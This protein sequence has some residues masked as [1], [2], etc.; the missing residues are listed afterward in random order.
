M[1]SLPSPFCS[2]K[3][4]TLSALRETFWKCFTA[5]TILIRTKSDSQNTSGRGGRR[6]K[7]RRDAPNPPNFSR[8]P[9]LS[10]P[11]L[12]NFAF[13]LGQSQHTQNKNNKK[14]KCDRELNLAPHGPSNDLICSS[15]KVYLLSQQLS[16]GSE[17]EATS[18]SNLICL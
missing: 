16:F 15:S 10:P 6:E 11:L 5:D 17:L 12:N 2:N 4:R 1:P 8:L 14:K 9:C 7:M 13:S 18:L 3:S